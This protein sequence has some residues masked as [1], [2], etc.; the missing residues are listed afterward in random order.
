MAVEGLVWGPGSKEAS[1]DFTTTAVWR[2]YVK[3]TC[4]VVLEFI[5][6]TPLREHQLHRM[7]ETMS[8]WIMHHNATEGQSLPSA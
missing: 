2:S 6:R 1:N 3:V 5:T 8:L 7:V 4:G